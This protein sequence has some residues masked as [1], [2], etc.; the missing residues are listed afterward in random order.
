LAQPS[1]FGSAALAGGTEMVAATSK[2][3]ASIAALTAHD[4]E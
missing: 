3:L 1:S 2:T 4:M